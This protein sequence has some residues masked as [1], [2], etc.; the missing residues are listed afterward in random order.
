MTAKIL[1]GKVPSGFVVRDDQIVYK[2]EASE[3][4]DEKINLDM[5]VNLLPNIDPN[6]VAKKIAGKYP[7]LAE[8]YL[9]DVPG[10]V[11]AEFKVNPLFPGKLGTLPHVT[12]K[13]SVEISAVK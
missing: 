3:E 13:I 6:D 9:K 8:S 11:R 4:D 12:K 2:F 7:T 10:F 5:E 1:E